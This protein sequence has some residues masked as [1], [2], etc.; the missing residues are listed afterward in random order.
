MFRSMLSLFILFSLSAQAQKM[1][2][3]ESTWSNKVE[4]DGNF[5]EW[6]DSLLYYFGDQDLHYSFAND[7]TYLYVAIR[8]EN[9]D[10]QIQAVFNGIKISISP[11]GKKKEGLHLTFPL[12]DRAALRAL[13]NQEFD[14]PKD[15]RKGAISAVRAYYVEG[16]PGILDGPVSLDNSYGIKA[17]VLIDSA[18]HLCYESAIRLDQ[19]GSTIKSGLAINLKINGLIR[20]QY[21]V[22]SPMRSRRGSSYGGYNGYGYDQRPRSV[23]QSR[24]EPGV[25]QYLHLATK[26]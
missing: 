13:S 18:D 25:W 22:S 16:F 3:Y 26:P 12:P 6:G 4:V 11:D 15:L 23:M 7:D 14:K 2:T 8:V 24:E 5:S 10:K 19:L 17:S 1:Q 9:K 20:T 21:N